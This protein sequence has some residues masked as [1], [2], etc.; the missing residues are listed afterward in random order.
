MDCAGCG[1]VNPDNAR[2][3]AGCGSKIAP[4]C[5]GC[6]GETLDGARFCHLCGAALGGAA[7]GGPPA[8]DLVSSPPAPE[9]AAAPAPVADPPPA[10]SA[11]EL[12]H[13]TV[14]FVDIVDSTGLSQR[15]DLEVYRGLLAAFRMFVDRLAPEYDGHVAQFM[16]DGAIIFFGYPVAREDAV[17][18]SIHCAL[19]LARG[20]A[21]LGGALGA[22]LPPVG[23]RCTINTGSVV[24]DESMRADGSFSK[25][26]FGDVPNIAERLKAAA[27]PG[28]VVVS[29]ATRRLAARGFRFADL[30]DYALKGVEGAVRAFRVEGAARGD[31]AGGPRDAAIVGR[32]AELALLDQRWASAVEGDGQAVMLSGEAGIGKS[33]L[34]RVLR[35][36]LA[37]QDRREIVLGGSTIRQNSAYHVLRE[38]FERLTAVQEADDAPARRAR[39]AAFLEAESLDPAAFAPALER[40]LDCAEA[41]G[42]S[43]EAARRA[44][45]QTLIG[46]LAA[47]GAERPLLILAE[48]LHWVDP[49]S[50]DFLTELATATDGRNW[51]LLATFRPDFTPPWP[52]RPNMTALTIG[53]LSRRDTVRLIEA[54]AGKPAPTE[55]VEQIVERTDGVPLFVEE[56]TKTVLES[57]LMRDAGDRF[58]L[59]GP[60]PPLSIPASLQDSLTARLDRLAAVKDVAQ[61]AAAIGRRF[62][63]ELLRRV[64][65]RVDAA[66][67]AALEKLT[68]AELIF[69]LRSHPDAE[70]EFK[71]ALVQDAAYQSLLRSARQDWHARIASTI[72]RDF[73]QIAQDEPEILAHHWTEARDFARGEA[74]WTEAGRIAL[75]RSANLEA[76]DHFRRALACLA[77]QPQNAARDRREL[78]LLIALA[79]PLASSRGY[80]DPQ[81]R[82]T[83][84]RAEALSAALGEDARLFPI[85]YG[86]FRS[87]MIGGDQHSAVEAARRLEAIAETTGDPAHRAASQRA[88]GSALIYRGDLDAAM[89][90]LMAVENAELTDEVRRAALAYDVVDLKVTGPAYMAWARWARGEADRARA[91]AARA[92]ERADATGHLFSRALA[93]AFASWTH[94][95]CG[96]FEACRKSAEAVLKLSRENGFAFWVGWAEVL[97]AA[98]EGGPEAPARIDEGIEDWLATGSAVGLSY[99]LWLKARA[100]IALGAEP[101]AEAALDAAQADID[102]SGEGWWRPEVLRL[103]AGLR[104]DSGEAV[105]LLDKALAAARAMGAVALELRAATDRFEL[106]GAAGA[107]DLPA[108]L[109]KVEAGGVTADTDRA[110]RILEN[111]SRRLAEAGG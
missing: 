63:L 30:G 34:V 105:A 5:P 15:L 13:V 11:A 50:L 7:L 79:V 75:A 35:E 93:R 70:F 19:E 48:D 60:L 25:D 39:I 33:S 23:L 76:I 90:H 9:P 64:S 106:C 83:Y 57:G 102:R 82:E 16:G 81:V 86:M 49:S 108:L 71:H 109:A 53:R 43:G 69:R 17:A 47:L 14:L 22:G 101:G 26:V 87:W 42:E 104:G 65:G 38:G 68:D 99:F 32:G 3:C 111:R 96:D 110:R 91:D 41:A 52:S 45:N 78:D 4:R 97:A 94:D 95:F 107:T 58:T 46:L 98:A 2:F 37:A 29:N 31:H 51:L 62:P 18:C 74:R 6:G 24:V 56:L 61:I 20:A 84:A 73:P 100:L 8:A 59:D 80:A 55:V 28:D 88:L 27:A 21:D 54:T 77:E 66:L 85:V 67:D 36:R 44:L 89:P 40:L 103:R 1:F 72:E 92:V 12:R 10:A